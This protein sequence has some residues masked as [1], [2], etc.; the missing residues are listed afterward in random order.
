VATHRF[1]AG[2]LNG[3]IAT[4]IAS[5]KGVVPLCKIAT[6]FSAQTSR[7]PHLGKVAG[8]HQGGDALLI[9]RVD[10]R[11]PLQ[12]QPHGLHV[13]APR[14][15]HQHAARESDHVKPDHSTGYLNPSIESIILLPSSEPKLSHPPFPQHH[16]IL[17]FLSIGLPSSGRLVE[18]LGERAGGGRPLVDQLPEIGACLVRGR[19]LRLLLR[20]ALPTDTCEEA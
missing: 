6:R 11:P 12:R 1:T 8:L 10:A 5:Q 3:N 19:L 14:R 7:P 13:P 2:T 4:V 20:L 9:P 18:S 16:I 15:I 17:A